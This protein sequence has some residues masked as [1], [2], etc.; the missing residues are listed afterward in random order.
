LV[1]LNP[2]EVGLVTINGV[3]MEMGDA[4]PAHC[5]LCYFPYMMGG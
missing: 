3:P 5:R 2:D 1:G 4:V